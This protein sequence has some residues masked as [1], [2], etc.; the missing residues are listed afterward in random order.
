MAPPGPARRGVESAA[1]RRRAL[2]QERAE[3]ATDRSEGLG[4]SVREFAYGGRS[5]KGAKPV[6]RPTT[7][8]LVVNLKTARA[9]GIKIPES[10]LMRAT[11]VIE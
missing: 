2:E 1:T 5:D 9:M 7:Y 11:R 6:E 3:N 10:V 8:E 4:L